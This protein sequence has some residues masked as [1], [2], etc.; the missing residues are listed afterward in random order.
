M[1]A[2]SIAHANATGIV[3]RRAPLPCRYLTGRF[4][5]RRFVLLDAS[6]DDVAADA[7]LAD[8]VEQPLEE[9]DVVTTAPLPN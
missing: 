7:A 8:A 3:V 5:D 6:L 4:L 1:L 9:G 2:T